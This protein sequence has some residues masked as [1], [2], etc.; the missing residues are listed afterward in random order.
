M[1]KKERKARHLAAAQLLEEGSG[2]DEDEIVEV[3]ASH[4]LEAYQAAPDAPDATE[5]KGR[6]RAALLGAGKR[7]ASLAAPVEARRYF[8]QALELAEDEA[9][10][11][12]LHEQ[13]GDTAWLGGDIPGSREHAEAART[14]YEKLGDDRGAARTLIIYADVLRADGR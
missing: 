5:I 14:M 12:W 7:A 13:A 4:Y 2:A 6:A 11:A 10:T 1:S 8:E 9:D 3:L